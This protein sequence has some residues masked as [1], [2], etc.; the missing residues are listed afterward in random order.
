MS[1]PLFYVGLRYLLRLSDIDKRIY[2][3]IYAGMP[4]LNVICFRIIILTR[5]SYPHC[6]MHPHSICVGNINKLG[7]LLWR[8][9]YGNRDNLCV[10][11]RVSNHFGH[12]LLLN[13]WRARH[14]RSKKERSNRYTRY[15]YFI[16][17]IQNEKAYSSIRS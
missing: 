8:R 5:H 13:L 6:I 1:L 7:L 10:Y 15:D 14:E 16:L 12:N 3:R 4:Y 11:Y 9:L 17:H 2:P